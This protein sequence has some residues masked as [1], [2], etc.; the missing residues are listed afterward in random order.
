MKKQNQDKYGQDLRDLQ[1]YF[2]TRV[3]VRTLDPVKNR[4]RAVSCLNRVS[5]THLDLEIIRVYL[6]LSAAILVS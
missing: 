3:G 4:S 5:P 6:R 1:D 2:Q